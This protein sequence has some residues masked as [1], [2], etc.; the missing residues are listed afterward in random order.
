V[1]EKYFESGLMEEM[2]TLKYRCVIYIQQISKL[3]KHLSEDMR[4]HD[5]LLLA[6]KHSL[7]ALHVSWILIKVQRKHNIHCVS[8]FRYVTNKLFIYTVFYIYIKFVCFI[9]I[10]FIAQSA[11]S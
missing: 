7:I 6:N 5:F 4:Y 8:V 3:T 9:Y 11:I 2:L 10:I 1:E